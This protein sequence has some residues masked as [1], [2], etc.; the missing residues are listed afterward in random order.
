M[1]A[2]ACGGGDDGSV[3][4]PP[5]PATADVEA[6]AAVPEPDAPTP[7]PDSPAATP[8][9][10]P[11]APDAPP[12]TPD[13]APA[14]PDA[15]PATPD[16]APAAPDAPPATPDAPP[17]PPSDPPPPPPTPIA[18]PEPTSGPVYGGTLV[19]GVEAETADG[20]N[21]TTTQC[22]VS[23]HAVMRAVFDPLVIED[24]TGT[25]RPYL[26]LLWSTM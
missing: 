5:A 11:A 9:A 2:A 17:P 3:T 26:R 12:A 6:P 22:A 14:A 18:A 1:L 4:A 19:F 8:D 10:P 15:P 16:A 24:E 25:P 13:A 20:W 23:C 7:S 21:P